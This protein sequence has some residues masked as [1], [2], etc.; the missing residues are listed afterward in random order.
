MVSKR[1]HIF[2]IH[3]SPVLT[4]TFAHGDGLLA[5]RYITELA[6]RGHRLAVAC[7]SV[8][9]AGALPPNVSLYPIRLASAKCGPVSRIEYALKM[10]RVFVR[11]NRRERFDVVHQLNPVYAGLS[12]GLLGSR[13]PVVLGPYVAHWP[14]K[15]ASQIKTAVLDAIGY[16]Q[17]RAAAAVVISGQAARARIVVRSV[18]V[19]KTYVVPYGIDINAFSEAP[20]P[21]GDPVILYLAGLSA[22]KGISTLLAAFEIVARRNPNARLLVAGDGP[23]RARVEAQADATGFRDR[24]TFAGTVARQM[25]PQTIA[26]CTVFCV[27]SFGEPYGMSL[28]EAMAT[29]RPVVATNAGGPADLVDPQGGYLVTPGDIDALAAALERVLRDPLGAR[30]MGAYNRRATLA[31]DWPVVIDQLEKVYAAVLGDRRETAVGVSLG[32]GADDARSS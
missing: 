24:I 27:A 8:K 20:F 21:S 18:R 5:Y 32:R 17:Q 9:I 15:R 22:R 11:L 13:T 10:R 3:P 7:E 28:V 14:F 2:I 30:A 12:L 25:V 26:A 16:L 29:G 1:L 31:Y 4:D 6:A 23:D 19:Q